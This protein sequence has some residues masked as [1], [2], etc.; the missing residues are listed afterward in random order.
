MCSPE[1]AVGNEIGALGTQNQ[2]KERFL[3]TKGSYTGYYQRHCHSYEVNT[4]HVKV[5]PETHCLLVF[6]LHLFCLFLFCFRFCLFRF[7]GWC[8]VFYPVHAFL[9]AAHSLAYAFHQFRNFLSAEE[10]QDDE[11][12]KNNFLQPQAAYK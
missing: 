3:H 5:L 1:P 4:Q 6:L 7:V 11:Y 8:R 12:Q 9:K 10:Q 2:V